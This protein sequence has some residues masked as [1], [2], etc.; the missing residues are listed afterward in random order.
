LFLVS[1]FLFNAGQAGLEVFGLNDRGLLLGYFSEEIIEST[2]ALVLVSLSALHLGALLHL[3]VVRPVPVR[4]RRAQRPAWIRSVGWFLLVISLPPTVMW[5]TEVFEVA[6]RSGYWATYDRDV[7]TGMAASRFVLSGLFVPALLLLTACGRK[8]AIDRNVSA[9]LMVTFAAVQFY[10]GYR[11]TAAM[12]LVA[13]AWLRHRAVRPIRPG[14]LCAV[15][16]LL[17]L[18][19]FP[20]VRETRNFAFA[21]RSAVPVGRWLDV[22]DNPGLATISEMGGSMGTIAYT[23][24]LVPAIRPYSRGEDYA[25][26]LLT[27]LPNMFWS[28]H[29]TIAYGTLSDWLAGTVYAGVNARGAGLG[30]SFIAEA[31]VNFGPAGPLLVMTVFGLAL[32]TLARWATE[33]DEPAK[34][35]LAAIVL[36]VILRYPRDELS[37]I[38]RSL[39]WF[40]M[41]P[42]LL[43]LLL[44]EFAQGIIHSVNVR[45]FRRRV[46]R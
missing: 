41:G 40:G 42:Y 24:T 26:A 6:A 4:S 14:L 3:A 30:Y 39:V 7:E 11:S 1:A 37:G 15:G 10:I 22:Q 16:L 8:H 23:L 21:D 5:L 29:P 28:I 9:I 32:V 17:L 36:A 25:Y 35:A 31:Y 38:I 19:V 46:L 45:T 44:P 13:W 43:A 12:P 33:T 27:L 34:V 18:V 20:L 2:L